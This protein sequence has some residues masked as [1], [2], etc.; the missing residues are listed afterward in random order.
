MGRGM[1]D[2]R[3][4]AIR[5]RSHGER[6]T[7]GLNRPAIKLHAMCGAFSNLGSSPLGG[8]TPASLRLRHGGSLPW[9]DRRAGARPSISEVV[10]RFEPG[11][12]FEN[13]F[14]SGSITLPVE[15]A[16]AST[17]V[18][19][20]PL[21]IAGDANA[22]VRSCSRARAR[23]SGRAWLNRP[24]CVGAIQPGK[25]GREG[26]PARRPGRNGCARRRKSP[27]RRDPGLGEESDERTAVAFSAPRA[28]RRH[29]S[30]SPLPCASPST[31]HPA[32]STRAHR[33]RRRT[34][35]PFAGR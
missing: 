14:L 28:R 7:P 22:A 26:K 23:L 12:G 24:T 3:S 5:T 35:R 33:G 27:G 29:R 19:P 13:S 8:G 20:A 21:L 31:C 2:G 25:V 15:V 11:H 9:D 6:R 4:T 18:L 1:S 16:T 30:A 17:A 34:R 10:D 32:W